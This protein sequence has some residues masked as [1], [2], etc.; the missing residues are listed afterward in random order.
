MNLLSK[1]CDNL[2]DLNSNAIK[3]SDNNIEYIKILTEK[4]INNKNLINSQKET[5]ENLKIIFTD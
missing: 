3:V 5:I 4:I 1:S 2:L